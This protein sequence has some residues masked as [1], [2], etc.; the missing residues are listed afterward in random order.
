MGTRPLGGQLNYFKFAMQTFSF[1]LRFILKP[2]LAV[3]S[4]VLVLLAR[5][6]SFWTPSVKPMAT[7]LEQSVSVP[8]AAATSVAFQTSSIEPS[9]LEQL[10]EEGET[11]VAVKPA[12][13]APSATSSPSV[14]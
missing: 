13:S 9:P 5:A 8:V 1:F 11:N 12:P 14:G 4:I 7:G 6:S 2:A 10:G 3:L